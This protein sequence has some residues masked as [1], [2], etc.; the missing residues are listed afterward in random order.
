MGSVEEKKA[1]YIS[2]NEESTKGIWLGCFMSYFSFINNLPVFLFVFHLR[3]SIFYP[4]FTLELN[5][6]SPLNVF[7]LIDRQEQIGV[8]LLFNS[9]LTR[10]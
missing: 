8:S 9:W 10:G 3:N 4:L 6:N 1:G 2:R 7:F 5:S